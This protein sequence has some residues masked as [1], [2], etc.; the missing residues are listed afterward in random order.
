MFW[1]IIA[2]TLTCF[3][4]AG[5][6]VAEYNLTIIHTNDF[7]GQFEPRTENSNSCTPE[8][9][10]EGQCYGGAA[11]LATA[12]SDSRA[13]SENSILV[14]AGDAFT[15]S[16]FFWHFRGSFTAEMMNRLSYD[17]MVAGNHEFD[18]GIGVF[19][20]ILDA[21]E[22]PILIANVE[23]VNVPS[24]TDKL[25]KSIIVVRGGEQLGIIGVTKQNMYDWSNPGP[26]LIFTD[27]AGAVQAEVN[28]LE[29]SGI[30]KIILL[31]HLGYSVDKQL[32]TETNGV[33]VIVGGHSH[34]HL[35]NNSADAEGPY[36]TMVN[37]TAIVQ[38]YAYS[39]YLGELNLLFNDQ[40]EIMEATGDPIYL[41][42]DV[43]EE[44][45]TASRVKSTAAFL[46]DL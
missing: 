2:F 37:G 42:R 39:K 4:S 29:T 21:A 13:R 40:G 38:V 46:A 7:H 26:D 28:R 33:D 35:H 12:I 1:K 10:S 43:E 25:L 27:P 14:D 3:L 8:E 20:D 9:N 41:G 30:N 34:T 18:E 5:F 16:K 24:L 31:S 15:G 22:F 6:A 45:E 36:P 32:A 17:A 19:T 11:R 44:E 23:T